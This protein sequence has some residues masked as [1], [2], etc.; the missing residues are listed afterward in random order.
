MPGEIF[1][2]FILLGVHSSN[3]EQFQPL[4]ILN[5][6]S[7]PSIPTT[8]FQRWSAR[9]TWELVNNTPPK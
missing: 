4:L 2:V 5:D 6:F 3:W 7:I 8:N 1:L 9:T